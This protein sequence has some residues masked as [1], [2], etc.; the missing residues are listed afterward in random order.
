MD[1]PAFERYL[2]LAYINPRTGRGL[3]G[4]SVSDAASRCRRVETAFGVEL[5]DVIARNEL[6]SLIERV[7]SAEGRKRLDY[8]GP[9][10]EWFRDLTA[11]LDK[12]AQFRRKPPLS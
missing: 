4:R 12:Y 2:K 3:E 11:A 6:A 9:Q 5:D 7:K 1:R 8:V 10:K